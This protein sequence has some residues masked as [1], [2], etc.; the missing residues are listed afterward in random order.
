MYKLEH[1]PKSGL[2]LEI[3]GYVF[4]KKELKKLVDLYMEAKK[5]SV[6]SRIETS[7]KEVTKTINEKKLG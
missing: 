5:L 4:S 3:L 7:K 6:L 2:S 1:R